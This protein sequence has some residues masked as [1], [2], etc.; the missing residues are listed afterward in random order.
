MFINK[1]SVI[2]FCFPHCEYTEVFDYR[3]TKENYRKT[4]DLWHEEGIEERVLVSKPKDLKMIPGLILFYH[5]IILNKFIGIK[6]LHWSNGDGNGYAAHITE[7]FWR[8]QLKVL[9]MSNVLQILQMFYHLWLLQ[10]EVSS[11]IQH[12]HPQFGN[13]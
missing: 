8:Y 2:N 6:I 4:S 1:V 3:K 7:M 9:Q 13:E 11:F 12:N 5:S 10:A